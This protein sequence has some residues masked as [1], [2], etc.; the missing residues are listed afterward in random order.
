MPHKVA[1]LEHLDALTPEGKLVG[2]VNTLFI[3]EDAS[4]GKRLYVG[5]NTDVVGIRDAFY[6]N[7]SDPEA[8]FYGRPGLVV[9][10]GGAFTTGPV[11]D[12]TSVTPIISGPFPGFPAA[13]QVR[14]E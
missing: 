13:V 7:I 5:T 14:R 1:I 8:R 10:G 4:T 11:A 9:G 12:L 6:Q 3:R 2:A